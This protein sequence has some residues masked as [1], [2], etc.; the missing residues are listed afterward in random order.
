MSSDVLLKIRCYWYW[1]QD[2]FLHCK[3]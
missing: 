1:I 2:K 3:N